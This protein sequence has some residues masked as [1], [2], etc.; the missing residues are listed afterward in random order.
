[1]KKAG[2]AAAFM[3]LSSVVSWPVMAAVDPGAGPE[4]PLEAPALFTE[5]TYW[6]VMAFNGI[7]VGVIL[8]GV[9][10]VSV[11]FLRGLLQGNKLSVL[12][13]DYRA[14]IG[15]SILLGLEFLLAA[16]VISTVAIA[17]TFRNVGILALIMLTRGALSYM[18]DK[19]LERQ[20]SVA[21]DSENR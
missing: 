5:I 20:G 15:R 12:Y 10:I 11:R 4:N 13:T 14:D 1:M 7:G 18:L 21:A 9:T 3:A 16:S 2:I 6:V 17:P 8:V 19:E